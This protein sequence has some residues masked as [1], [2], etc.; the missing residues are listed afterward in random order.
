MNESG[1]KVISSK[2]CN[3]SKNIYNGRER[4]INFEKNMLKS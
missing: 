3:N 2:Y 4:E 1:M